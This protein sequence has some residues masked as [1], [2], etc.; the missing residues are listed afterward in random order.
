M[1]R[2][3]IFIL[4]VILISCKG[5]DSKKHN[6]NFAE[7]T[8]EE[9]A[10]NPVNS[11]RVR[12]SDIFQPPRIIQLETG[13]PMTL[14]GTPS[15]VFITGDRIYIRSKT[16]IFIFNIHGKFLKKINFKGSGPGEAMR[17][18]MF[19]LQDEKYL[20]ILSN[21]RK[22][23]IRYT[24]DGE[25]VTEWLLNYNGVSAVILPNENILL[26]YP[27]I[28]TDKNNQVIKS[29]VFE[30]NSSGD[31]INHFVPREEGAY[32]FYRIFSQDF[33]Y[34]FEGTL[35]FKF[36]NY[37]TI[38][39]YR[40]DRL[41]PRIHIDFGPAGIPSASY[42][43]PNFLKDFYKIIKEKGYACSAG[44]FKET[45][46]HYIFQFLFG[47]NYETHLAIY[48]KKTG[49]GK[50]IS[51]LMNDY[52]GGHEFHPVQR[53]DI[54]RSNTSS[55]VAFLLEPYILMQFYNENK[56]YFSREELIELGINPDELLS[57]FEGVQENDNPI[58]V[59]YKI[60]PK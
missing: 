37:D 41:Q 60:K 33:Y 44:S 45:N 56:Q 42:K 17:S 2:T 25:F 12:Y 31:L 10:I 26:Y 8:I 16:S 21:D 54:P 27:E 51:H 15:E 4:I 23:I 18:T 49:N 50:S 13:D 9:V 55:E 39:E 6:L 1:K 59:L 34:N 36:W 20:D 53:F 19:I 38:Y 14:V 52:F 11:E 32:Q 46:Q 30:M 57:L 24:C 3:S 47:E 29:M 40:N 48:N 5:K 35:L 43:D 58:L 7:I 28:V 22:R